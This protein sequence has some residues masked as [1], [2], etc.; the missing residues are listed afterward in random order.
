MFDVWK[1]VLAEIEQK[2]SPAAFNTWFPGV[3]LVSINGTEA[4]VRAPSVF[5]VKQLESRY[6][7]DILEAL[8]H[9]GKKVE[10]ITY[11]AS[12]GD[13]VKKNRR[14]DSETF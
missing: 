3:G 13:R 6:N 9:N 8:R 4:V 1:N 10:T 12:T 7:E 14:R 11:I 2:I 5:I